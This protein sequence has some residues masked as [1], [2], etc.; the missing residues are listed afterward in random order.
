M[1]KF[2]KASYDVVLAG[3]AEGQQEAIK[4]YKTLM[5]E[6]GADP[7]CQSWTDEQV[8]DFAKDFILEV[9]KQK[10]G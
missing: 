8:I 7:A 3:G 6:V 10:K 2:R 1:D 5:A 9:W 4:Q